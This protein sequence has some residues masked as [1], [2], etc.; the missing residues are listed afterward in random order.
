MNQH[1]LLEAM[2]LSAMAYAD[3]QPRPLRGEQTFYSA[4]N[5][6]QFFV[7]REGACLSIIFRGSNSPLDWAHNLAFARMEVAAFCGH[8]SIQAHRGFLAAYESDCVRRALHGLMDGVRRLRVT[9]HSYGAALATLCAL[10]I[11]LALPDIDVEA[12]LFGAPRVGNKAFMRCYNSHVI[13]TVR[14][15][16]GNDIVTKVPLAVMGFRH[17][18]S[19]LHVGPRRWPLAMSTED[20]YQNRYYEGLINRLLS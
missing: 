15:E 1:T 17:V 16:C 19:R 4:P 18:G 14:V 11:R 7:R 12:I 3:I 2:A 10:D 20:H 13:R 6:V 9:G 5:G 8:S